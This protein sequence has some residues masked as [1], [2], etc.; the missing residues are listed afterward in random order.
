MEKFNVNN[1]VIINILFYDR[2]FNLFFN[3]RYLLDKSSY[4]IVSMA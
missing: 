1:K 2:L 4:N 3:H